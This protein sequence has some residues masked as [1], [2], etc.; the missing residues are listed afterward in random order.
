M[1]HG[2]LVRSGSA[3]HLV[4][5]MPTRRDTSATALKAHPPSSS[6]IN[7]SRPHKPAFAR[8]AN[9]F[10]RTP[11]DRPRTSSGPNKP[12][13]IHLGPAKQQKQ[14]QQHR[15]SASEDSQLPANASYFANRAL[16]PTPPDETTAIVEA[17]R[18]EFEKYGYT[19][20]PDTPTSAMSALQRV[21]TDEMPIGMALG[22]PSQVPQY[23]SSPRPHNLTNVRFAPPS[24]SSHPSL[25]SATTLT[26]SAESPV[27]TPPPATRQKGKWKLFGGLFRKPPP[28]SQEAFYKL[29]PE[30]AQET[31]PE[32]DWLHFPEPPAAMEKERGWGRTKSERRPQTAKPKLARSATAPVDGPAV[33]TPPRE[34]RRLE[35]RE[36][37]P[38]D[39]PMQ[40]H[41]EDE[42]AAMTPKPERPLLAVEIPTTELERYSVMFSSLLDKKSGTQPST[43]G[44]LA[45]RQATLDRLKSVNETIA[46]L[47]RTE[48]RLD[49]H[50][51]TRPRRATSPNPEYSPRYS[52]R[53]SPR[54]SQSPRHSPSFSLFPNGATLATHPSQPNLSPTL[55]R[56]PAF[57]P[58]SPTKPSHPHRLAP[59]RLTRSNTSPAVLTPLQESF[60][61][62]PPQPPRR[63]GTDSE[64]HT[65][66]LVATPPSHAPPPP[67]SSSALPTNPYPRHQAET[68]TTP[69]T[70]GAT[71]LSP[72]STASLPATPA[73]HLNARPPPQ[74]EPEWEMIPPPTTQPETHDR[75]RDRY[76]RRYASP[77]SSA[78]SGSSGRGSESA[79]TQ[80]SVSSASSAEAESPIKAPAFAIAPAPMGIRRKPSK[81]IM[82][83]PSPQSHAQGQAYPQQ[84]Q[85]QHTPRRG[86][87]PPLSTMS[88]GSGNVQRAEP[89]PHVKVKGS[90]AVARQMSLARQRERAEAEEAAMGG[91]GMGVGV[92]RQMS[93]SRARITT[94]VAA[95]PAGVRRTREGHGEGGERERERIVG[96]AGGEGERVVGGEK[97]VVRNRARTAQRVVGGEGGGR[98]SE[99]GVL[100]G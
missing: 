6:R 77:G 36:R 44:L 54:L 49:A 19:S 97:I 87:P 24:S 73:V 41:V 81:P 63:H 43:S 65:I 45:R 2:I 20:L 85:Q 33:S 91:S 93:V 66:V 15:R 70:D 13:I 16:P 3:T 26:S 29:E 53:H 71:L 84:Q 86:A 17:R 25:A 1:A 89:V 56:H 75:S 14:K 60:T 96:D 67:L 7:I 83:M 76:P 95:A 5:S 50:K 9:Y 64:T 34:T 82:P 57:N 22:S 47:E 98:K 90:V 21:A 74:T 88:S 59:N 92:A 10:T 46:E 4:P 99:Y 42:W 79:G 11:P 69:W 72:L 30:A 80:G 58:P 40:A 35:K 78:G 48:Q 32:P 62:P 18:R 52:P 28:Q 37:V 12:S 38:V 68:P 8:A 51:P 27:P 61:P 31:D 94:T 100:V 55:T 39:T 23:Q